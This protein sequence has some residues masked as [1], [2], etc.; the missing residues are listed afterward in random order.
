MNR[1]TPKDFI[2]AFMIF[3]IS[4]FNLYGARSMK[5]YPEGTQRFSGVFVGVENGNIVMKKLGVKYIIKMKAD[6]PL[7]GQFRPAKQLIDKDKG[8]VN[9]NVICAPAHPQIR[10][11]SKQ[12]IGS[13]KLPPG[14]AEDG[15]W[16][17]HK[18]IKGWRLQDLEP[19]GDSLEVIGWKEEG[20]TIRPHKVYFE[21]WMDAFKMFDE[22]LPNLMNIGDS[23][24]LG[25]GGE[26]RRQ[27]KGKFNIEHPRLNCAGININANWFGAY[28]EP[29][30][31]WDVIA[32]N[33]GHWN[34]N[35]TK[36]EYMALFEESIQ[37][38]LK[39]GKNVIWITTAP[40]PFGYNVG[41]K[42][43]TNGQD[44]IFPDSQW[45]SIQ[46]AHPNIQ[47]ERCGRKPGRMMAQNHWVKPILDKYPQVAICDQWGFV[48]AN[49][50]DKSSP[51]AKW[52]HGKNVHFKG[53]ELNKGLA[54][55][56]VELSS[57]VTGKK[58]LSEVP[59]KYRSFIH[60]SPKT[61]NPPADFDNP[62]PMAERYK[63]SGSE[64]STA[65]SK[66]KGDINEEKWW[67]KEEFRLD[68]TVVDYG[69]VKGKKAK[70]R[71]K[72]RVKLAEKDLKQ[73]EKWLKE[74]EVPGEQVEKAKRILAYAK[75]VL[76]GK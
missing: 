55:L 64:T 20:N 5:G 52:M 27:S 10:K 11:V 15:G 33:G 9:F 49:S 23:I 73:H 6:T 18:F 42:S 76:K 46:F 57:V 47:K 35:V 37:K 1:M 25:Y 19:F 40:V 62:T 48:Y 13:R 7:V 4:G 58:K 29:G 14:W 36:D 71:A 56:I 61:Y 34:S 39:A 31:Q 32:F 70:Q 16:R 63:S 60:I 67:T 45:R 75:K 21:P 74:G 24:S 51:Y 65:Q 66:S 50:K 72:E 54:A 26:L 44:A 69:K 8:T 59:E 38:T 30:R 2:V 43:T 12:A 68:A 22:K 3:L 41:D 17:H 28:D 53:D